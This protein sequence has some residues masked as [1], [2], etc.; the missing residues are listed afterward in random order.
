MAPIEE[1]NGVALMG[2]IDAGS[3]AVKV[4]ATR[5]PDG[6]LRT[7]SIFL[8][9]G[10]E[11]AHREPDSSNPMLRTVILQ[12]EEEPTVFGRATRGAGRL[13]LGADTVSKEHFSIKLDQAGLMEVRDLD[14]FNGTRLITR[15]Q[16]E[17]VGRRARVLSAAKRT[18]MTLLRGGKKPAAAAD[19]SKPTA[20]PE[21][22]KPTAG[23]DDVYDLPEDQVS[24]EMELVDSYRQQFPEAELV[25]RQALA[26]LQSVTSE[27]NPDSSKGA[28]NLM[29]KMPDG[30]SKAELDKMSQTDR[31]EALAATQGVTLIDGKL[32]PETQ[33]VMEGLYGLTGATLL[34]TRDDPLNDRPA[35][36]YVLRRGTYHGREIYFQELYIK[37]NARSRGGVVFTASILGERSEAL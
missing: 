36:D 12:P 7:D 14:S 28:S 2:L 20:K 6:E 10:D 5:G 22:E 31:S 37:N 8:I 17:E 16:P 29:L 18:G 32:P 25:L 24:F 1:K 11:D 9:P 27:L 26:D 19:T 23:L 15:S 30:V 3:R 4:C 35:F 21:A 13:D 34:N 33:A